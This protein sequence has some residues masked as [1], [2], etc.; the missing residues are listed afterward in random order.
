MSKSL[1]AIIVGVILVAGGIGVFV[2]MNNDAAAPSETTSVSEEKSA[3]STSDSNLVDPEGT[4][5]LFSD[6]SVTKYPEANFVFGNGQTMTFEYDGSKTGNDEYA[7]LTYELYYIQDDGTVV[8]M[9]NGNLDGK[10]K[11]TFSTSDKVFRSEVDGRKGFVGL[12][13]TYDTG[14]DDNG[15]IK[16]TNVK[17]GMYPVVYEVSE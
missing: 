8:P 9:T 1:L 12:V 11:G 15:S 10:G 7:T 13:G 6:P 2:L 14:L 16:G 3:D 5:D 17:L 4:Y